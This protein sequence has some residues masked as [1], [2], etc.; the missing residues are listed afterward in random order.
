MLGP[1][2]FGATL[3]ILGVRLDPS[4]NLRRLG[5][6]II[7]IAAGL[8]FNAEVL[9]ELARWF[10]FMVLAAMASVIVAGVASVVFARFARLD[11]TTSYFACLP[12]GLAEMAVVGQTRGARP[13]PV[14]LMHT[15][16]V[17]LV[18]LTVP[19]LLIA[20]GTPDFA[21]LAKGEALALE[22]I[23]ALVAGGIVTALI[24]RWLH[25]NNPFMIGAI[26]FTAVLASSGIVTGKLPTVLFA[27][28]QLL[29]GFSV[30]CRFQRDVL[31]SLPRVAIVGSI[32]NLGMVAVMATFG[33]LL[34]GLLDV[35]IAVGILS[36]S[37]GGLAEMGVTA[38][39]LHLSVPTILGFQITRGVLVNSLATHYFALFTRLGI[40]DFL[41]RILFG[42]AKP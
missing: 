22:W 41:N 26:L 5:Q 42:R 34:A 7:G 28:A 31:L 13:E 1:L 27:G 25:L 14:A 11:Q 32:V 37:P 20:M 30:G 29:I 38:Q 23:V 3:S 16:R 4:Q 9:A 21:P 2:F 33:L 36:T 39:L 15:L 24:L 19:P 18:V 17:T 10:P 8:A 12:G 35:P 40:L 6:T